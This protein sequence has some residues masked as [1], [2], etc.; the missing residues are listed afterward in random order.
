MGAKEVCKRYRGVIP[1]GRLM[2]MRWVLTL[3]STD[4]PET[5]KCKARIVLLG[6]TDP[7]IKSLQTSAPTMT[8]RSRQLSLNLATAKKWRL[9]KADAKSAFL[10][11]TS[12]QKDRHI[13]AIPVPELAEG[14]GRPE[15]EAVQI[16]KAAYS[17]VSAPRQWF[18]EVNLVATEDCQLRQLKSDPCMCIAGD[19][20]DPR[21][22]ASLEAFKGAFRW[23]PWEEPPYWHCGVMID[24]LADY[25]FQLDHSEFCTELKQIEVNKNVE[26]VTE[27]EM[28]QCR[29]VLGAS[30]WRVLQSGPQHAAKLS[31]LRSALPVSKHNK[32]ILH[33][34]YAERSMRSDTFQCM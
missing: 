31:W 19:V 32:D 25:S 16:L 24:Q 20:T 5:A 8:R 10:Q 33:Q 27:E 18:I 1:A 6:F 2:K 12:S 14:L 9:G 4:K 11:G 13:F 21:W 29:A 17:L 15:G 28:T 30:Q 23:S 22:R 3:K 7:G 34:I 26:H